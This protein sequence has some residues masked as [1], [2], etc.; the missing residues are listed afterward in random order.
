MTSRVRSIARREATWFVA[1]FVVPFI[2]LI[3]LELLT[4]GSPL[5]LVQRICT[6]EDI[7]VFGI[8][9]VIPALAYL[10]TL[11]ARG[12]HALLRGLRRLSH[13]A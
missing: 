13:R 4:S 9:V 2:A 1:Y 8:C 6:P 5:S 10:L 12:A 11:A 7:C 3:V